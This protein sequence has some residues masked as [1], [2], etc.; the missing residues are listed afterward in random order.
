VTIYAHFCRFLTVLAALCLAPPLPAQT[1][2]P[3]R[4]DVPFVP[5]PQATVEAMLRVANVGPNDFVIDLGSGDGRILITA[6]RRHGARGFGVDI[7]PERVKEGTENAKAAGVSA[8]VQF[9]QKNLYSTPIAEATVVTMYLLPR[10]NLELRP[11]LLAEL[12]PG[13][14]VVSHD[15]DMGDWQAD[16]Q[17][18]VRGSGSVVYLWIIPAQVAGRWQVRAPALRGAESFDIEITQKYQ[19]IEAVARGLDRPVTVRDAWLEGGRIAFTLVDDGDY[20]H[21]VRFE[22][23]VSSNMMEGI[24][25]GD[26]S[27]QRGDR[28]WRA[29]K[30]A[31]H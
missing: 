30:A 22:G 9:F 18:N 28:K 27:A 10:V 21:R 24:A 5:T 11:R 4:L 16:L 7:N 12:K 15:F 31:V 3:P 6:A 29:T 14:R 19:E 1:A 8:R 25:R 26:G 13:T 2:A 20:A 23:R 17:V